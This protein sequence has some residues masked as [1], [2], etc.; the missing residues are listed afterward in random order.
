MVLLSALRRHAIARSLFPPTTLK[1]AISR[2]GCFYARTVLGLHV[3]DATAG[4][5]AYHRRARRALPRDDVKADGYGFQVERTY[6]TQHAGG[7]IVE[8]PITFRARSLGRS[9]M[10]M[11]IVVEAL[12]LVTWWGL[13]DR[14]RPRSA[15]RR[16][17]HARD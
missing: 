8:M 13:R 7:T 10:S 12:V 11:R 4:F 9:K 3:Q 2:L 14:I 6:L 5:R 16:L 15:P 17:A 1:R